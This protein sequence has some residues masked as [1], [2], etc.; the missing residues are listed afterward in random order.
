MSVCPCVCLSVIKLKF[1]LITAFNVIAECS[2]MLQDVPECSKM[3]KNVPEY[4][5]NVPECMQNVPECM[6]NV[7]E[8]IQNV[9]ENSRMH[10]E[11]MQYVPECMQIHELACNYISLHAVT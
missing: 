11:C 8:C 4:V 7:P 9:P 6:Q 1:Y 10:T 5:Q 3:F 2:R